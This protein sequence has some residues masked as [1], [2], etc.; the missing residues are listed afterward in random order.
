M[1]LGNSRSTDGREDPV[2]GEESDED[3]AEG[4]GSGESALRR[5]AGEFG[6]SM[7]RGSSSDDS[8]PPSTRTGLSISGSGPDGRRVRQRR[9]TSTS[10]SSDSSEDSDAVRGPPA[11]RRRGNELEDSSDSDYR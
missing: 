11:A 8:P 3:E 7:F 6:D 4:S 2:R 10:E 9:A 5:R 1:C